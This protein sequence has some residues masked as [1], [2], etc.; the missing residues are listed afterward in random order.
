[1]MHDATYDYVKGY[2]GVDPI[3]GNSVRHTVTG[4]TGVIVSAKEN[5]HYV[6]VQFAGNNHASPCHPTE[7]DYN[8]V[9]RSHPG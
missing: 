2:Y 8:P 9:T 4:Q 1:M 3:I 6:H 7:L 5:L